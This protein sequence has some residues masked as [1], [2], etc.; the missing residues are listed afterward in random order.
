MSDSP[1]PA[2]EKVVGPYVFLRTLG[3]GSTGRVVLGRHNTTGEHL[4]IKVVNKT[5]VQLQPNL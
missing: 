4:A 2:R 3:Q 1:E 5:L